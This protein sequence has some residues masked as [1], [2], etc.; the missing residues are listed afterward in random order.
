VIPFSGDPINQF[1]YTVP[2]KLKL[3][4]RLYDIG[5]K[6]DKAVFKVAIKK[7][8]IPILQW[9]CDKKCPKNE[10]AACIP[11]REFT[12]V[13]WLH[14]NGYVLTSNLY[15]KYWINTKNI[16][17]LYSNGCPLDCSVTTC[18]AKQGDISWP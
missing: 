16:N 18:F 1:M 17:Y 11:A 10:N 6:L 2:Q 12:V 13:K 14:A 7:G 4:D 8:T 5:I 15:N 9:L 3:L